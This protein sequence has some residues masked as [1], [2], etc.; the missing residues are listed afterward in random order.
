MHALGDAEFDPALP[1]QTKRGT[2]QALRIGHNLVDDLIKARVLEVVYIGRIPKVTTA[3]ILR[4]AA[5]GYRTPRT[6]PNK[7]ETIA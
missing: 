5:T 1:L 4:V 3:S 6:I 2:A 7:S